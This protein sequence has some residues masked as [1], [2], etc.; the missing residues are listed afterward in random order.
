MELSGEVVGGLFFEGIPGPQFASHQALRALRE[1][2]PEGAI[3]FHNASDPASACGLDLDLPARR[4]TTWLAWRGRDLALVA[5]ADGKRLEFR[6]PP[7]HPDLPAY[8]RVLKLPCD[9]R[10]RPLPRIVVE[11]IGDLPAVESP[12]AEALLRWGFSRDFKSLVLRP[13]L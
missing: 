6:I 9:R 1:A 5:L 7:D 8:L 3:W 11:Q 2:L 13:A 4:P 12:Y 10:F